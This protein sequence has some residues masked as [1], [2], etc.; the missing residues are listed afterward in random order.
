M[1][2]FCGNIHKSTEQQSFPV[3]EA[4]VIS[5]ALTPLR[6]SAPKGTMVIA[7]ALFGGA[8]LG[9]GFGI[10]RELF[11]RGFRTSDQVELV[12]QKPCSALIPMLSVRVRNQNSRNTQNR[13]EQFIVLPLGQLSEGPIWFGH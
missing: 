9:I 11:D 5:P 1:T 8:F 13:K 4:R 12:L 6:K 10:L 2:A 3:T 7:A